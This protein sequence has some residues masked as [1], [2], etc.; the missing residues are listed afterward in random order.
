LSVILTIEITDNQSKGTAMIL[1]TGG[2]GFIGSHAVR[3]LHE[4]GEECVLVQRNSTGTPPHLA[5]LP[6][7][8][9]RGDVTDLASLRDIGR[10]Y[11]VTGVLHLAGYHAWLPG[12][13]PA[14]PATRAALDGLLNVIEAADGWG[15]RRVGVASTI[16]VYSGVTATGPLREDLPLPLTAPHPIPR[17][18]KITELLA[19][20]LAGTTGME[21]VNY[22]ISGTWGPLGHEDPFFAAPALVHAAARGTAPDLSGLAV[23]PHADDSLDLCYVKDTGRALALLQLAGH[24]QHRTYNIGSGRTTSNAQVIAAIRAVVPDAAIELPTRGAAPAP[25]LDLSRITSDTGY[26]PEFDTGRAAADYLDWL[27]A[28]HAR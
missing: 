3:A 14:V 12:P 18:K 24:L 5:D 22:R 4:L 10:R 13:G 15:V 23:P 7:A 25:Y 9:E 19:E 2:A 27:R 6:V 8:V 28:G 11:P 16:G 20:Q 17:S 1:V 21:I 26:R